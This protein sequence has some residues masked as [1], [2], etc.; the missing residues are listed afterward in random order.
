MIRPALVLRPEPGGSVTAGR[1]TAAG[2]PVRQLP[3]FET[4]AIDWTPPIDQHD[5]L[6]LTSANAVRHAGPRLSALSTLPVVAVGHRTAAA[7]RDAGLTVAAVGQGDGAQAL[8]LAHQ[9]G[10]QRILRLAARD[11]TTLEGVTDIPVY[12]SN[13]LTPPAGALDM[14]RGTVS[15]L[16]SSRA[17]S[18]FR[19]LLERD[20]V[21]PDTIRLA[22][23]SRAVADTAGTGW[24]RIIVATRPSDAA[25]VEVACTLAIDP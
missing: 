8:A 11:R 16:H 15:L 21:P 10:W 1:L 20:A 17:A 25:L 4:A 18:M 19:Q 3:L 9:K 23:I 2:L 7:A 6:L 5:A 12:A 24:D 13:A 22:A 14:A